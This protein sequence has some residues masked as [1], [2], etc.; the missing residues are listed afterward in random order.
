MLYEQ[1]RKFLK[2]LSASQVA[3]YCIMVVN[4]I[5]DRF[6]AGEFAVDSVVRTYLHT[7]CMLDRIA[8]GEALKEP[9]WGKKIRE[10]RAADFKLLQEILQQN[11]GSWHREIPLGEICYFLS[12]IPTEEERGQRNESK[13]DSI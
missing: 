6:F 5:G 8:A 7:A 9:D 4:S 12:S 1:V 11:S 3:D 13:G 10:E 2:V